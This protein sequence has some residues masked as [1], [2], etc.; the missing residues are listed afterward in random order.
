MSSGKKEFCV[1]TVVAKLLK[2]YVMPLNYD[3]LKTELNQHT[4]GRFKW[5]LVRDITCQE[6]DPKYWNI[7]RILF[8]NEQSVIVQDVEMSVGMTRFE[9]HKIMFRD[10]NRVFIDWEESRT[11]AW[12]NCWNQGCRM[13]G[14]EV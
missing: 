7:K 6:D 9:T 11:S 12:D 13:Y 3:A 4:Y 10:W 14:A 5:K 8:V 2:D 1:N